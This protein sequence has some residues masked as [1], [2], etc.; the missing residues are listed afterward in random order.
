MGKE[1]ESEVRRGGRRCKI[2]FPRKPEAMGQSGGTEDRSEGSA[3]VCGHN[4]RPTRTAVCV[5]LWPSPAAPAWRRR[6]W[7]GFIRGTLK[8]NVSE[9]RRSQGRP[10][11]LGERDQGESVL[12]RTQQCQP[13]VAVPDKALGIVY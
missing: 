1:G 6:G 3:E 13:S 2:V 4:I 12:E 11:H 8:S 9:A 7:V 5:F 10:E